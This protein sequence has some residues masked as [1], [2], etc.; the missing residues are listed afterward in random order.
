M[1]TEE[2]AAAAVLTIGHPAGL[3]LR[4][5]ALFARTAST[6][7]SRVSIRNL[8]RD[9]SPEVDAK[10]MLGLMQAAVSNGHRVQVQASGE[11]AAEAVAALERLVEGGFAEP[12]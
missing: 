12:A 4:P 2:P 11:D 7:K 1:T 6:F 5:A 3:H 9:N 10:S 8:S